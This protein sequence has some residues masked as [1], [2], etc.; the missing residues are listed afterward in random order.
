MIFGIDLPEAEANKKSTAYCSF[1]A[2]LMARRRHRAAICFAC[3]HENDTALRVSIFICNLSRSGIDSPIWE[4]GGFLSF[5]YAERTRCIVR[6]MFFT[7]THDRSCSRF[8]QI[9]SLTESIVMCSTG[10]SFQ[11]ASR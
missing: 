5:E 11:S 1:L 4:K 10:T 3:C 6:R 2:S 8:F 7:D 9:H